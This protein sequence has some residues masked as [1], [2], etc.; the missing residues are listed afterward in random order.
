MSSK[1]QRYVRRSVVA[2]IVGTVHYRLQ[3]HTMASNTDIMGQG[4]SLSPAS[5]SV[6]DEGCKCVHINTQG[7]VFVSRSAVG[8]G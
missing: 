6:S 8:R 7:N 5:T 3:S 2:G 4:D 1:N